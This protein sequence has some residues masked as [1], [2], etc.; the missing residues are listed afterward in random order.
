MPLTRHDD[1]GSA[2]LSLLGNLRDDGIR[3]QLTAHQ[4]LT[5]NPNTTR[6]YR[7]RCRRMLMSCSAQ[8]IRH[9]LAVSAQLKRAAE[10]ILNVG[11]MKG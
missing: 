3:I 5:A 8:P 11:D 2:G 4:S 1:R 9:T 7:Y 6:Q 10:P